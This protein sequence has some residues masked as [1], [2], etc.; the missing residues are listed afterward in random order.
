MNL[1]YAQTKL[2]V[3]AVR[4]IVGDNDRNTYRRARSDRRG[5][6]RKP[7]CCRRFRAKLAGFIEPFGRSVQLE[8]ANIV[9]TRGA[10]TSNASYFP[11]GTDDGLAGPR[12]RRWPIDRSCLHRPRRRG[13]R[14]RQLRP[15]TRLSR[16]AVVLVAGPAL[17]VPMGA[18]RSQGRSGFIAQYLLPL[19]RLS[20]VAGH[21]VGRLQHLPFDPAERRPA[22]CS[23]R[24]TAPATGSN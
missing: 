21:A 17:R 22:G 9:Q 8:L 15:C 13:R 19:L 1:R 7:A 23:R 3:S 11:F 10:A 18:R 5:L 20:A 14:N 12:P 4:S 2:S 16:D 24:R 6:R